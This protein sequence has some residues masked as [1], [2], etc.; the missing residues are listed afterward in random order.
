[1]TIRVAGAGTSGEI[2]QVFPRFQTV[3]GSL[4]RSGL[5]PKPPKSPSGTGFCGIFGFSTVSTPPT[6]TTTT[7][8]L[9]SFLLSSPTENGKQRLQVCGLAAWWQKV[10]LSRKIGGRRNDAFSLIRRLRR[11]TACSFLPPQRGRLSDALLISKRVLRT[12]RIWIFTFWTSDIQIP[13]FQSRNER[14]S[15]NSLP[16]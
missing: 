2:P 1:M 11:Q 6:T 9:L 10:R 15:H 13:L 5:S 7:F 3:S 12:I 4:F 8:I 16:L 14:N